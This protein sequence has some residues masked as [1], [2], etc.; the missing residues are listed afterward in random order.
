MLLAM[1]EQAKGKTPLDDV[2]VEIAIVQMREEIVIWLSK[3]SV[4]ASF[5]RVTVQAIRDQESSIER[6]TLEAVKKALPIPSWRF[7]FTIPRAE[8]KKSMGD[9]SSGSSSYGGM[10]RE[11]NSSGKPLICLTLPRES[12][13]EGIAPRCEPYTLKKMADDSRDK[14]Y[15]KMYYG[16]STISG[17][18]YFMKIKEICQR[19]KF[20]EII[21]DRA[22]A[23]MAE[24]TRESGTGLQEEV[25]NV[26]QENHHI[27]LTQPQ[28]PLYPVHSLEVRSA[29]DNRR[30]E[31]HPHISG[32]IVVSI[33]AC[34]VRD[35]GSIPGQREPFAQFL[36]ILITMLQENQKTEAVS[37]KLDKVFPTPLIFYNPLFNTDFAY[38]GRS[39][40]GE[41]RY[42]RD[43]CIQGGGTV[44]Y[45]MHS[46]AKNNDAKRIEL[47]F[48]SGYDL[49]LRD[50]SGWA[51]IH[52]AAF[53]G[54]Q[55]ALG[56]LIHSGCD[57]NILNNS[58]SSALH[59]AIMA[60]QP[61][62]VELLLLHPK[63]NRSAVDANGCTPFD[64][65]M[66]KKQ[67]SV[68]EELGKLLFLLEFLEESPKILVTFPDRQ[69]AMMK[70]EDRK[71]TRADTL[72]YE[73]LTQDTAMKAS[74]QK[75]KELM[76]YFS[77]CIVSGDKGKHPP[78]IQL[79][80]GELPARL[81]TAWGEMS[82]GSC[83]IE[84][85][86]NQLM[87]IEEEKNIRPNQTSQTMLVHE[88]AQYF[89]EGWLDTSR[90]DA[91][92]M[93]VHLPPR[94]AQSMADTLDRLPRRLRKMAERSAD[95][96][97]RLLREIE[98]ETSLL[99]KNLSYSEREAKFLAKARK[100]ITYGCRP[101]ACVVE[102]IMPHSDSCGFLGVN[103]D[104][105]HVFT[106]DQNLFES[107][108]WENFFFSS[109]SSADATVIQFDHHTKEHTFTAHVHDSLVAAA[110]LRL[111]DY[112]AL[113]S[114]GIRR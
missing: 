40:A 28:S 2:E 63:I 6:A 83:S 33:R 19:V 10:E 104:G 50:D 72:L 36:I 68:G 108:R 77:I 88:I 11:R 66:R 92:F 23:P 90:K 4:Q 30:S 38:A 110:I 20:R 3:D 96:R 41:L 70:M 26:I 56:A 59:L 69:S 1:V 82:G 55:I 57:V 97:E 24:G 22:A 78:C 60:V 106:F 16:S 5:L 48:T 93:T 64:L 80:S 86:R 54:H 85:R 98:I 47:L 51:P 53:L 13:L 65:G 109:S 112:F 49:N 14:E 62:V 71:D 75:A 103:E 27:M 45:E 81:A 9:S 105:V 101:Y 44:T 100:S 89:Q 84:I 67:N 95:E 107:Y 31:P 102:Y 29:R 25:A 21:P 12:S 91:I 111:C 94:M 114:R 46:A 87:A 32:S 18:I 17:A 7:V 43:G 35:P 61:F 99:D 37:K 74:E 73:V 76:S 15:S 39:T 52:Y 79:E 58:G 8:K 42:M 34:H 113:R